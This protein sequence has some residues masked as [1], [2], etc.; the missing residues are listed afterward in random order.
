MNDVRMYRFFV[1]RITWPNIITDE[2]LEKEADIVY[3][4]RSYKLACKGL[5]LRLISNEKRKKS[6]RFCVKPIGFKDFAVRQKIC[7][8]LFI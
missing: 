5:E 4:I 3:N 6:L 8:F 2:N 7:F 1:L